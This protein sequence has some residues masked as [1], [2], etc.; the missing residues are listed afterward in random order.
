MGTI[1]LEVDTLGKELSLDEKEVLKDVEDT[2][3]EIE[4]YLRLENELGEFSELEGEEENPNEVLSVPIDSLSGESYELSFELDTPIDT[5]DGEEALALAELYGELSE[6]Q[7]LGFFKKLFRKVRKTFKKVGRFIR[8]KPLKAAIIA[9]AVIGGGAL[10]YKYGLLSKAKAWLLA[11]GRALS[12][13]ARYKKWQIRRA[14]VRRRW[15]A[16][17]K[18]LQKKHPRTWFSRLRSAWRKGIIL[19]TKTQARRYFN[20]WR[21]TRKRIYLNAYRRLI[22]AYRRLIGRRRIRRP[23]RIGRRPIRRP[24]RAYRPPVRSMKRPTKPVPA[25]MPV[26]SHQRTANT[27]VRKRTVPSTPKPPK[28]VSP[29]PA[30]PTQDKGL[31]N[32]LMPLMLFTGGFMLFRMLRG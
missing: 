25:I 20:L 26:R 8:R 4:E 13:W 27:T 10:A 31:Q 16:R 28:P 23:V 17:V 24:V 9:G 15:L 18:K 3:R 7:E 19:R 2:E 22:R 11:K 1:L 12:N 14:L 5:L 30:T 29:A 32:A 21:R 6:A